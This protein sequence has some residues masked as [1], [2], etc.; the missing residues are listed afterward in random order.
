MVGWF[1]RYVDVD[2]PVLEV[3]A[4]KG[5]DDVGDALCHAEKRQCHGALL[6]SEV[7]QLHVVTLNTTS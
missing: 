2:E 5:G 7:L 1:L 6:Q 4:E 3:V